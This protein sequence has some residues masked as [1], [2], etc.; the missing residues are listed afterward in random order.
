MPTAAAVAIPPDEADVHAILTDMAWTEP[1][2][3]RS[4]VKRAGATLVD[5]SASSDERELALAV[6]NNWRSS[7]GFPLNT[8]QMGLRGK[9]R[10]HDPDA[11]VAQRIKR[12]PSIQQK[13]QRFPGM[14]LSRMQDL[15]GCRAVVAT[16][17]EIRGIEGEYR[18]SRAKHKLVRSDDYIWGNPKSSGYRGL[19]L[20]F[21]YVSDFTEK[22]NGLRIEVQIRSRLQHAWATAVETVGLFTQQA[23]KA[24]RG[25]EDWLRFF[26]LMSSELARQ[27]G[28]PIIPGTPDDRAETLRELR[29]KVVSLDVVKR[30]ELFGATLNFVEERAGARDRFFLLELHVQAG[31]L[32]VRNYSNAVVANDS[33]SALERAA[34]DDPSRDVVLVAVESISMLRRAYPNYFLDT[35][36]FLDA[37]RKAVA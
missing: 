14:D 10:A 2:Y 1:Q 4:E 19:H 20:V 15:G 28:T 30:L 17:D 9:A 12:L 37:V 35:T 3:S 23:L 7:H 29:R 26:A 16:V 18:R 8:V 32:E 13:L 31:I 36:V 21:S 27:E 6:I 24:S 11:L 22:Y 5:S 25:T 33:Y 34:A